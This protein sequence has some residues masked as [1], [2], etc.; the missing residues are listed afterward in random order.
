M[1]DSRYKLPAEKR[2]FGGKL[3]HY[4]IIGTKQETD[5]DAKRWRARGLS[6]RVVPWNHKYAVYVRK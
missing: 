4:L 2:K 3:Y 6:V 5:G 1:K